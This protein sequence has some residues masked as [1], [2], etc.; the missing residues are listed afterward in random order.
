VA[1]LTCRL[2]KLPRC[3]KRR[4]FFAN[5]LPQEDFQGP[6]YTEAPDDHFPV[7]NNTPEK[8]HLSA[9]N[10]EPRRACSIVERFENFILWTT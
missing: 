1:E 8:A 9:A 7:A 3:S 4:L 2:S 6:I 5:N 10:S